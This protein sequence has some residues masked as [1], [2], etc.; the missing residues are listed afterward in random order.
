MKSG[1]LNLLEILGHNGPVTGLL[2][3]T[4]RF[5]TQFLFPSNF[6]C[7]GWTVSE[8]RAVT[9]GRALAHTPAKPE[10][11]PTLAPVAM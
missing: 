2:Y 3:L 1:S 5:I 6:W 8:K 11:D 7:S 9:N 10:P 4:L